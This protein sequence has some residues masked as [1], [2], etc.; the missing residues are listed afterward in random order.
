M[1]NRRALTNHNVNERYVHSN[2]TFRC[3][4][5]NK[6]FKKAI[7]L[8][9]HMTQHTGETLYKCP[10]CT[11]TFNSNA[12]MH[13]HKKKQ[14]PFVMMLCCVC[15]LETPQIIDIFDDLGI[16]LQ[17]AEIINKHLWFKPQIKDALTSHICTD[18]WNKLRDFHE[19]YVTVKKS[20]TSY[21]EIAIVIKEEPGIEMT[22]EEDEENKDNI[23][24]DLKNPLNED[25]ENDTN[26]L[27]DIDYDSDY[28]PSDVS[29]QNYKVEKK[30]IKIN[31]NASLT[32]HERKKS[33]RKIYNKTEKNTSSLKK[34]R[35]TDRLML[36][37]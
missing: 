36:P 11:R 1:S 34:K 12:N 4:E 29:D 23:V 14:H 17:V 8:R 32:G 33:R 30:T 18:C 25:D 13:A 28:N 22:L 26:G 5:C 21:R 16:K 20:H 9:E 2:P 19:F 3:E 7:S 24:C 6:T 31:Q 37:R 15:L 27:M 35:K 10:F